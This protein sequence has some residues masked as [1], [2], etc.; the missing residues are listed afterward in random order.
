MRT[1]VLHFFAT[2]AVPRLAGCGDEDAGGASDAGGGLGGAGGADASTSSGG[3]SATADSGGD[4]AATATRGGGTTTAC[5][6]A[7]GSEPSCTDPVVPEVSSLPP[8][9]E[10]PDPFTFL[11]GTRMTSAADWRCRRAELSQLIQHFQYGSYPPSPEN[12]TGTLNGDRL[13][14][15]VEYGG[16]SIS[17]NATVSLPDG[18][19]PFSASIVVSSPMPG[20][21]ASAVDDKAFGYISIDPNGIAA[22][23]K[24]PRKGKLYDLDGSDSTTGAL[25]AWDW[26]AGSRTTTAMM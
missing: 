23:A 5:A 17:C 24:P 19:G 15:K 22:D 25:L 20:L 1:S 13:T 21:T 8:I 26:A 18:S 10:P 6:S 9:A 11:D 4:A 14:V 16:K 2:A 3:P 7:G 12:V